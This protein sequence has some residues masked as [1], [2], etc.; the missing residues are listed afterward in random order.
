MVIPAFLSFCKKRMCMCPTFDIIESVIFRFNGSRNIKAIAKEHNISSTTAMKYVNLLSFPKPKL[1]KQLS[2][3]EYQG[4][5]GGQRFQ[6]IIT[7]PRKKRMLDL[8]L[9]RNS[10]KLKEY[11]M[12]CEDS[13]TLKL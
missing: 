12:S 9:A 8:L 5:A 11:F 2:I 6:C 3:D 10:D 1:P 13:N 7:N 4:N